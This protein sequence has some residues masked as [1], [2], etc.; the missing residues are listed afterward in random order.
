MRGGPPPPNFANDPKVLKIL[1]SKKPMPM[2][3]PILLDKDRLVIWRNLCMIGRHY[4]E[5]IVEMAMLKNKFYIIA[6][7]LFSSKFHVVELWMQQAQKLVRACDNDLEK[8]MKMLD[9]KLGKLIIKHQDMLISWERFMPEKYEKLL[10]E[11][12]L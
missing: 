5:C 4:I 1:A 12:S 2:S 6:L 3:G 8:V 9:F 10:Q 7:D 11:K